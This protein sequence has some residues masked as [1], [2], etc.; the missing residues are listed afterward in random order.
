MKYCILAFCF[1][2]C[3]KAEADSLSG[4]SQSIKD[5]FSS[6]AKDPNKGIVDCSD[7]KLAKNPSLA[8]FPLETPEDLYPVGMKDP[9]LKR[10]FRMNR[11]VNSNLYPSGRI[12]DIL[13]D[14]FQAPLS[15]RRN[16][17][18]GTIYENKI[19]EAIGTFEQM[20]WKMPLMFT[21]QKKLA[22]YIWER[23]RKEY[24]VFQDIRDVMDGTV[25]SI[26]LDRTNWD[27]KYWSP[28]YKASNSI[29]IT[30]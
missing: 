24:R 21:E 15:V 6:D 27:Y 4:I 3:F 5:F 19:K 17:A 26:D 12:Y 13:M 23:Y 9:L 11:Y 30:Q 8:S 20:Y 28:S 29:V 10:R 2:V 1:I 25:T 16:G 22:T 7:P 14:Y 18:V